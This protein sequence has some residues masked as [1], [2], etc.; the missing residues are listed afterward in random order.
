M[1]QAWA[2][3]GKLYTVKARFGG[4]DQFDAKRLKQLEDEGGT[5]KRMVAD[6]LFDNA[7]LKDF[8]GKP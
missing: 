5:Q 2:D 3:P 1:R 7:V 8:L 6:A 4:M